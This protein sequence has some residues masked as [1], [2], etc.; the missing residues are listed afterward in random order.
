M[1]KQ[2]KKQRKGLS[3]VTSTDRSGWG[4]KRNNCPS[5]PIAGRL[6]VPGGNRNQKIFF[7]GRPVNFTIT[8]VGQPIMSIYGDH[9]I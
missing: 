7:S 2:V 8:E 1:Q 9:I 6:T 4:R 3:V 5:S